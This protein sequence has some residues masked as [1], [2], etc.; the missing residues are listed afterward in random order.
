[1]ISCSKYHI[2]SYLAHSHIFH[3]IPYHWPSSNSHTIQL[4]IWFSSSTH[5][6]LSVTHVPATSTQQL[7]PRYKFSSPVQSPFFPSALC[8]V[9]YFLEIHQTSII[10][11]SP[12]SSQIIL[13]VFMAQLP[14]LYT[15]ALFT[16]VP[17][18]LPFN[19]FNLSPMDN[20]LYTD[21]GW[22]IF[23]TDIINT[24]Y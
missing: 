4:T 17:Y 10:A 2:L 21:Q 1:M 22:Q 5:H 14:L 24:V 11:F 18:N 13:F 6:H 9:P 7:I 3:L 19:F 23:Y 15:I 8:V 20:A 12:L 16:R